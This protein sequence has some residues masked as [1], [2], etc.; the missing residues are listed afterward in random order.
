MTPS[1]SASLPHV[2]AHVRPRVPIEAA[3]RDHG[4]FRVLVHA[5]LALLRPRP[6]AWGPDH[7]TGHLRRDIGLPQAGPPPRLH[8]FRF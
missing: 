5:A 3:I 2:R 4:A 8:P 7:L 1:D 6:A